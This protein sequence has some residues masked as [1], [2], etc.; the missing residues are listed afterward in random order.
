MM[1]NP[2]LPIMYEPIVR[3]AL[4]EDLGR[5]GDITADAIVP[6]D[7]QATLV[8]RARQPGVVAGLDIARC[9]FQ[10][11]SPAIKLN[12]E[13]PDG[14]CRRS[15]TMGGGATSSKESSRVDGCA[16]LARMS[17]ENDV[18]RGVLD[19]LR[20]SRI[21]DAIKG[22]IVNLAD[23]EDQAAL[24]ADLPASWR[25]AKL[26]PVSSTVFKRMSA[27]TGG[28]AYFAKTW[29]AQQKAFASIRSDL[30]HLYSLSYYPQANPN[31]GW[32]AI[33]VKLTG[34]RAKGLRVRTRN[35]YRPQAARVSAETVAPAS[36]PGPASTSASSN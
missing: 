12:A 16:P 36:G 7:K 13:R 20:Q 4:L 19:P 22:L 18:N 21:R 9:A 35:G 15:A 17:S 29:R 3:T 1:L 24:G 25:E 32:R 11:A 27:A 8:L 10:F 28:E 33:T 6:A 2:L 26:E 23:R 5:A 34:E 14:S 30:A 31:R